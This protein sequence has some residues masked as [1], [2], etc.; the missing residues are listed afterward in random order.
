MVPLLNVFVL[1][2]G[3][4]MVATVIILSASYYS[5][6]FKWDYKITMSLALSISFVVI[7]LIIGALS[8]NTKYLVVGLICAVV[9]GVSMYIWL[10]SKKVE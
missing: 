5:R 3:F 9:Q 1:M 4:G 2:L 7:V 8:G 10:K 6:K